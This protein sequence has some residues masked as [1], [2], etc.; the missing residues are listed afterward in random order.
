MSPGAPFSWLDSNGWLVLSGE[1]DA[2][3]EIRAQAL[4][5]YDGAGAIAYI[6][7]ANDLG[8][9]LMDDMAELG[10]PSGYLVDLEE[11]DN[12][13]IYE[14]LSAAGMIVIEADRNAEV[15]RSLMSQTV[16]SALKSALERGA[17]ILFEGAAA[18]IAGEHKLT[19]AGELAAGINFVHNVLI[20][21]SAAKNTEDELLRQ[22]YCALPD[23]SIMG[24][25]PGSAL[26]L[27]PAQQIET[28]GDGAVTI[29]LGDPAR[30]Y[31]RYGAL[32]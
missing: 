31:D 24:L 19:A 30:G 4:S 12:N 29:S 22:V 25:A 13:E 20:S 9:A 15:L 21:P 27:G 18:S 11:G 2:L 1:P 17:L 32:K 28:W 8:D 16:I 6:S 26:A 23:V 5:R 14:R 3:S 7:L 10:A